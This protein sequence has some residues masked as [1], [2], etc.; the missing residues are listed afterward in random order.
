MGLVKRVVKSSRY[1]SS[2][3]VLQKGKVSLAGVT[4]Q[5]VCDSGTQISVIN[6]KMLPLDYMLI[7]PTGR[8]LDLKSAW[9]DVA[10]AILV[11][12]PARLVRDGNRIVEIQICCAVTD[13]LVDEIALLTVHDV[14]ALQEAGSS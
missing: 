13:K 12:V 9:G 11:N 1:K 14:K 8:S 4:S 6:S 5:F 2:D 3:L 10:H 7:H